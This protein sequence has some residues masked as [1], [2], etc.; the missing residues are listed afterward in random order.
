M[1]RNEAGMSMRSDAIV[2]TKAVLDSHPHIAG[3]DPPLGAPAQSQ[4]NQP[5]ND[6][7]GRCA[8]VFVPRF[9]RH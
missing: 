4:K 6:A 1:T 2:A 9:N 7:I 8:G 3:D 5:A